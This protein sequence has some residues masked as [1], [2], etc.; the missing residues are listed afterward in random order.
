MPSPSSII[1]YVE[2]PAASAK[3]YTDILGRAP[4]EASPNFVMFALSDGMMLGLW[5]RH[6]VMPAA[7]ARGG[8]AELA[9]TVPDVAAVEAM[10]AD[11]CRRSIPIVQLPTMMDF[12][13]TFL[14]V[15]PDGHRLRV[16]APGVA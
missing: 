7:V 10:H 9:V 16:F 14:A 5:A 1:L 15:D 11:W 12:G 3:F 2:S 4:L 6:D 13:Y 8:A